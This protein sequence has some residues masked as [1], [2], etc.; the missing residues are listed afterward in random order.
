MGGASREEQAGREIGEGEVR[1]MM[2]VWKDNKEKG[3][4]AMGVDE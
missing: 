3:D 1:K 2:V 4:G